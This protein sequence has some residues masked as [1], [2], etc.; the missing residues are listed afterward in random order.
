MINSKDL[1]NIYQ[2]LVTANLKT[3]DKATAIRLA[4]ATL[5][6][7]I[8]NDKKIED[9]DI[10]LNSGFDSELPEDANIYLDSIF[11]EMNLV[12]G[13]SKLFTNI[14]FDEDE[15]ITDEELISFND[16]D[17]DEQAKIM[18]DMKETRRKNVKYLLKEE[19]VYIYVENGC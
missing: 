14:D 3:H 10:E 2:S 13:S 1:S 12:N 15:L 6:E 5:F 18:D 11:E 8:N 4:R 17:K 7:L 16:K 9:L 19:P